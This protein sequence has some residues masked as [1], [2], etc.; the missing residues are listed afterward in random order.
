MGSGYCGT[1]LGGMVDFS[2]VFLVVCGE[3]ACTQEYI[4]T[5]TL[6]LA[7]SSHFLILFSFRLGRQNFKRIKSDDNSDAAVEYAGCSG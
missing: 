4:L 3:M 1:I 5:L 6:T 7:V 2:N